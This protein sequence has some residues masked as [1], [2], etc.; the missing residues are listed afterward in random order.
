MILGSIK[1]LNEIEDK[2]KRARQRETSKIYID[3]PVE[4]LIKH[5][6]TPNK[7]SFIGFI[8]SLVA[9]FLIAIGWIYY[10]IWLAWLIPCT[11]GV[12]GA[13]DLFDGEVARRTDK[14]TQAGAFLDSNLDRLSD[15]IFILSL[16]YGGLVNYLLGYILLF[17]VL[18]I[19]YTRSR[20]ENEGVNTK[21]IGFMERADRLMFFI[22]TIII[23]LI[24]YFITFLLLNDPITI[25]VPFIT[26]VPVSPIFLSA[27]IFYTFALIYTILQRLYFTFKTLKNLN[28][29]EEDI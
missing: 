1:E 3:L 10:S 9:S 5:N 24:F 22:F 12:G 11:L 16:I 6:I 14:E 23:E 7:I 21:G 13:F 2:K 8:C 19:S 15:T 25:L 18:M 4:F 20:A 28:A 27:I 29:N 17:L 26:R